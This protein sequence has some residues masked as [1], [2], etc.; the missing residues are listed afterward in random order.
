MNR[1]GFEHW[2]LLPMSYSKLNQWRSYPTQFIINRIFKINTGTNPAMFCGTIVEELLYDMLKGNDSPNGMKLALSDFRMNLRDYHNQ[3]EVDKYCKL[4]PKF[5][6]NCKALFD[7]FG[8]QPIHSYQE[9]LETFIEVDDEIIPFV[10][11]SDFVWDLGDE[12]LHIFD[13][14]TKGRMAINH[15]DKLQQYI[16]KKALEE[17]YQKPVHCSLFIV[18]PT[19]HHFEEIEFTEEHEIEIKNIL[20]GMSMVLDICNDPIDFAHIY[21]PNLSDFIWNNPKLVQARQKIWGI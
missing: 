9:E 5:Y 19:K 18:T 14:K 6:E 4:I 7:R 15:S 11:Y 13:L 16:Y 21:Q 20:K 1:E 17:K 2:D 8:N 10:G 3:E 12:G